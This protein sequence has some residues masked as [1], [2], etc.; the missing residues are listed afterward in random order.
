MRLHIY[1]TNPA[2]EYAETLTAEELQQMFPALDA[3]TRSRLLRL[4]RGG[5]LQVG[6]IYVQRADA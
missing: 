5:S 1:T 2:H 4:P 6:N 3:H